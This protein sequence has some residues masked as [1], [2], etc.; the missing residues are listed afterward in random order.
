MSN[1]NITVSPNSLLNLV[2]DG[3]GVLVV[4]HGQV[5]DIHFF[6]R[7]AKKTQIECDTEY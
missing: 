2:A 3:L 6:S 4:S 5:R 7:A 1:L